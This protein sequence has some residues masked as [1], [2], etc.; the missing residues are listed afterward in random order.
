LTQLSGGSY[1]QFVKDEVEIDEMVD[2]DD[3]GPEGKG[4]QKKA[5]RDNLVSLPVS[6]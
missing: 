1:V 5:M 2:V 3:A 4:V 6:F